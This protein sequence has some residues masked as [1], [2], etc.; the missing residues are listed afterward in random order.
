LLG[1]PS[2]RDFKPPGS[3]KVALRGLCRFKPKAGQPAA[4]FTDLAALTRQ[5]PET[6]STGVQAGY[7]GLAGSSAVSTSAAAMWS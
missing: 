3:G 5:P 6:G 2:F 7:T 4:A 1:V